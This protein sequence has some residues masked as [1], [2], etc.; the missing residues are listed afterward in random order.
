M[1]KAVI[2]TVRGSFIH[3]GT[4]DRGGFYMTHSGSVMVDGKEGAVTIFDN[5]RNPM[6]GSDKLPLHGGRYGFPY[7]VLERAVDAI[8]GAP[9]STQE[10]VPCYRM[11]TDDEALEAAVLA[12]IEDPTGKAAPSLTPIFVGAQHRD[13]GEHVV[14]LGNEVDRVAYS[15]WLAGNGKPETT[16]DDAAADA[17][18]A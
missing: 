10:G 5:I 7:Q 1:A 9:I 2:V 14:H 17:D 16:A 8:T 12:H 11:H 4:R 3:A 6:L 13:N 18:E 15:K